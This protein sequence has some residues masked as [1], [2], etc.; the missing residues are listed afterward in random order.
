MNKNWRVLN[1]N[2]N[3]NFISRLLENRGIKEQK[4]IDE[5]FNPSFS[6]SCHD[7]FLFLEMERAVSRIYQAIKDQE[8]IIIAG[9]YDVDGITATAILFQT[10]RALNG[11]VSYRLPHRVHDGYG[12]NLKLINELIKIG[13]TVLI[14]ADCGISNQP[15][16]EIAKKAGID[17]IITDHHTIPAEFPHAAFAV[18]HGNQPR[19]N[20]PF[21]GLTGAGVAYKLAQALILK[22][23]L[24][25]KQ[26]FL[27]SIIDLAA[28]G[29]IADLGPLNQENRLF[30]KFGLEEINKSRRHGLSQ[31]KKIAWDKPKEKLSIRDIS[32]HIAPRLNA[33]GRIDTAY[34]ALQLL[35]SEGEKA[36]ELA[37]HLQKLNLKRQQLTEKALQEAHQI[38]EKDIPSQ[39]LLIAAHSQWHVGIIG[40]VA[41]KFSEKYNLPSIIMR[42]CGNYLVG[43]A[44]SP[45]YFN[46]IQSLKTQSHFLEHFGGHAQAAGFTIKKENLTPF[47]SSIQEYA[48]NILKTQDIRPEIILDA[49][50]QAHEVKLENAH[51]IEKFAPFGI[52]NPEPLLL[53]RHTRLFNYKR[54][55]QE[56]SHLSFETQ[57]ENIT[58]R[59]IAFDF[60]NLENKIAGLS[61]LDLALKLK[62]NKWNDHE[63]IEFEVLDLRESV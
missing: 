59:S 20:Y 24:P 33:A 32:F 14:T 48:H 5:F 6:T 46:I 41:G 37:K 47:V 56:K 40:L 11:K 50:I 44:R 57:K 62:T 28:L 23:S 54:V 8:K 1:T 60:A 49:E 30:A 13:V 42:D 61:H 9:D 55:G 39:K 29:T 3:T 15:E 34:F 26:D 18:I 51:A 38:L 10:L 53:F 16:I 2:Q 27:N 22:S 19:C 4:D 12:L 43:S 21:R 7:P 58:V 52:A 63:K 36:R 31:L 25:D 35:L 17:V 45:R